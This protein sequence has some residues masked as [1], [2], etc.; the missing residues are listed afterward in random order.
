VEDQVAAAVATA[1]ERHP[2][3]EWI[4][5][6]RLGAEPDVAAA[7]VDRIAEVLL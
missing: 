2:A 3:I 4:V 7:L 6:N 5:A 1:R